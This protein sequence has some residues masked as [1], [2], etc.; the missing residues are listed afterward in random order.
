MKIRKTKD[1]FNFLVDFYWKNYDCK[2]KEI[3]KKAQEIDLLRNKFSKCI[4][5]NYFLYSKRYLKDGYK[6]KAMPKNLCE[7]I[8]S[9]RKVHNYKEKIEC[10][11]PKQLSYEEIVKHIDN[12]YNNLQEKYKEQIEEITKSIGILEQKRKD[13]DNYLIIKTNELSDKRNNLIRECFERM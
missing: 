2:P 4:L 12:E 8:D 6:V 13:L 5:Y 11:K 7:A 10:K 9:L 1:E 3:V